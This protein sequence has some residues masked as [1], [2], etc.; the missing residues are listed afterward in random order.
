MDMRIASINLDSVE[1]GSLEGVSQAYPLPMPVFANKS[2][3]DVFL[4]HSLIDRESWVE[5]ASMNPTFDSSKMTKLPLEIPASVFKKNFMS[6]GGSFD[7][8]G[9]YGKRPSPVLFLKTEV[10]CSYHS[11]LKLMSVEPNDYIVQTKSGRIKSFS[12]KDFERL[13][14]SDLQKIND[15]VVKVKNPSMDNERE[16][17]L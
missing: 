6:L 12:E 4:V 1:V 14:V 10:P 3:E 8:T 16:L 5:V 15:M 9:I 11:G 17:S 13:F 2:S 7:G